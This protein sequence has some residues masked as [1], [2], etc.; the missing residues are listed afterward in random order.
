MLITRKR[1]YVGSHFCQQHLGH[2]VIDAR[3]GVQ[4]LDLSRERACVLLDFA[5]QIGDQFLLLGRFLPY[6]N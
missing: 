2:A 3:D 4:A 1:F 5:I 6:Q